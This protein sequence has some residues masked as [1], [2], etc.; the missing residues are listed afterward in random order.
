MLIYTAPALLLHNAGNDTM[1]KATDPSF[2]KID[3]DDIDCNESP[4]DSFSSILDAR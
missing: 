1:D 3:H 4:N 2:A